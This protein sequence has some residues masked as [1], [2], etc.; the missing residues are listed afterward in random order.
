[1]KLL[2]VNAEVA[3]MPSFDDFDKIVSASGI[4]A[5]PVGDDAGPSV[6]GM[7]HHKR[8]H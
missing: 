3:P 5:E 7:Y 1:V 2:V 8:R 6:P 4:S